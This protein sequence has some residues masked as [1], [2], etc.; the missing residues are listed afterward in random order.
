MSN[1]RYTAEHIAAEDRLAVRLADKWQC[2][3][4]RMPMYSPVDWYA[5]RANR[6]EA[7]VEAKC[8][9]KR[10][11]TVGLSVH[12]YAVLMHLGMAMN[13]PPIFVVGLPDDEIRFID[14]RYVDP[15]RAHLWG[16]VDRGERHD[17]EP[18][19]ILDTDGMNLL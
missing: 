12:K 14:V 9:T 5:A 4:V 6:I 11:E 2:A 13:I 8:R 7:W 10:V 16:R 1:D 3:L 17:I 19:I 15:T 18:A